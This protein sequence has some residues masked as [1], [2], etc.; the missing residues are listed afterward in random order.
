MLRRITAEKP[1]THPHKT[2]MGHPNP[3]RR[4]GSEGLSPCVR[5]YFLDFFLAA[6][7]MPALNFSWAACFSAALFGFEGAGAAC[8]SP[9]LPD[10]FSF[11]FFLGG[12]LMPENLRRIFSR[13]S[14]VLPRPFSWA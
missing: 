3:R 4:H 13:S 12:S 10:F 8:F 2:R 1:T 11:S 9:P 5:A 7:D 6:A 14:G